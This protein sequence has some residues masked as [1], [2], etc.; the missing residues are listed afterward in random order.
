MIL[1]GALKI[2]GTEYPAGSEIP[3]Y[4][5]YPFFLLH[6][7]AF[8]GSGFLMAYVSDGPPLGFLFAHGGFAILVYTVFYLAIFGLDEVKWM[9]INAGLGALGI[10]TQM[11]WLL[12]FFGKRIDDY[13]FP[14]HIIPFLYYV[15]YTFLLRQALL[16]AFSAREDESRRKLAE[17]VFVWASLGSSA[18]FYLLERF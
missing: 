15:L 11:G 9:F 13:P 6:M 3:W 17:N 2:G 10:Y 18:A 12:S 1:H 16:D 7:L 14:R 5:V 8:G 4:K